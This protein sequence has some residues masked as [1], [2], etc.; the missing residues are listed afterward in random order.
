[1]KFL[2]THQIDLPISLHFEYDLGGAEKGKVPTIKKEIIYDQMKK[3]LLFLRN[4]WSNTSF[5]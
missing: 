1:M 4:T 2:K 3:D 5:E